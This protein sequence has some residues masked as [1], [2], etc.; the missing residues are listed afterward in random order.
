MFKEIWYGLNARVDRLFNLF[1]SWPEDTPRWGSY[2]FSSAS[3][4]DTTVERKY[5]KR[6]LLKIKLKSLM[7]EV[8]I[9]RHEED[10]LKPAIRKGSEGAAKMVNEMAH[11]RR[12]DLRRES[13]ATLLAY[14]FIR[15]RSY[16]QIEPNAGYEP[17]GYVKQRV[18][19]VA[20]MVHKYGNYPPATEVGVQQTLGPVI[21]AWMGV[22]EQGYKAPQKV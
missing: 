9:I 16:D 15:G 22:T 8:K 13:R 17:P 14:G 10:K 11:H 12:W 21:C 7:E 4:E 2:G 19:R 20:K 1:F 6:R 5:D 3:Q 18:V